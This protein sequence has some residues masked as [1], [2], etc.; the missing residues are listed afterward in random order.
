MID[1]LKK[2]KS[3]LL[4]CLVYLLIRLPFLNQQ[5]LL[6]DERDIIL[7]GYSIART[8]RDLFGN[9][10]PLSFNHISPDNPLFA[11]Y[12][13]ALWWL[14]IPIKSV[15]LARLPFVL[16]TTSLVFIVHELI[17]QITAN[18]K[19]SFLT[20]LLFCFS[21]W[22]F[23]ITRLALDIPLAIVT[24]TLG[25]LFYLKR[26]TALSFF[27]FFL[28]FY[29]Y[30][31]FRTIIP[32][33]LI[34]LEL[35]FFL[36]TKDRKLFIKKNVINVIFFILLS[37]SIF[38]VDAKVTEKR[39]S[40]LVFLN[41]TRFVEDVNY[42]RNTSIAPPLIKVIFHNKFTA[43]VNYMITNFVKGQDLLYLFKEG[44]T[45]PI[46]GNVSTGQFFFTAIFFYYLGIVSFGKKKK[47][48]DFF[49][50]GL[51]PIGLIPAILSNVSSTFSIRAMAS[52]IGFAYIIAC[53]IIFASRIA[54][55]MS[56]TIQII[57]GISILIIFGFDLIYF[58]YNYFFRRPIIVAESFFENERQLAKFLI[59]KKKPFT[60]YA[61]FPQDN[62]L[63]LILVESGKINWYTIQSNLRK[64]QPFLWNNKIIRDCGSQTNFES[65]SDAIISEQC[66]NPQ[67]Y[68]YFSFLHPPYPNI[69]YNDLS[70]KE[71]YFITK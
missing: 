56:K 58:S 24:L 5:F 59:D 47:P 36:K 7:S 64:G 62:Y 30:Q 60:V 68:K 46:N 67:E 17:Y 45:S 26:K 57:C 53:G 34:Y 12:F 66:L 19:L 23:H 69:P 52:G 4:L 70:Y 25:M 31:G 16:I 8:G 1:Y 40:Q 55:N 42:K 43:T 39:F 28:T 14:I 20:M 54:K 37:L 41:P 35:F 11:I 3:L 22:V 15:F 6:H 27:M 65:L 63:S 10:M 2:R 18:K 51:I 38:F 29:T 61:R 49:P 71:A 21:P 9:F 48:Q 44:D 50:L 32:F 13:S 33:L